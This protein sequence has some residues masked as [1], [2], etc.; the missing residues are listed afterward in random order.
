[1]LTSNVQGITGNTGKVW[2]IVGG[3]MGQGGHHH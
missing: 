2:K 3:S 1:V